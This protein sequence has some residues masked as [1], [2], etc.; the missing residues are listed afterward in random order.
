MLIDK[1]LLVQL[2]D[3]VDRQD[4]RT[5]SVD[6]IV[7]VTVFEVSFNRF[8][9]H[10]PHFPLCHEKVVLFCLGFDIR[11]CIFRYHFFDFVCFH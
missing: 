11:I 9:G 7:D 3:A 1:S 4:E 2:T 6:L 10:K 8:P 5:G